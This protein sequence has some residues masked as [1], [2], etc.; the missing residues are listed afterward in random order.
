MVATVPAFT[1][2]HLLLAGVNIQRKRR[3]TSPVPDDWEGW[4]AEVFPGYLW[5]P[6]AE[7]HESFWEWVLSIEAD[8][9]A[10]P[11]V[12]IWPRGFAKSTSTEVAT[13]MLAARKRRKYVLYVCSTQDQADTHVA[14]IAGML[15][16]PAFARHFPETSRRKLGKYGNS[17]GWRRNRLRTLD[18]FTVDAIGMD[19]AAR[20]AKVDEDRPDFIIFDDIDEIL[21]SPGTV[22][23]KITSMT[24]SLLPA[25]AAHAAVLVAQNLIHPDGIVA[26]LADGRADFLADRI[27]SGPHPA[28]RGM[29]TERIDGKMVITGGESTWPAKTIADLQLDLDDV[30]ETAF[31]S[32]K[33]HE[34]DKLEGGIFGH[35]E[36]R[37]CE[38][39]EVPA[40][41]DV[42]V[43]VD[44]AVT[45]KDR[46]DSHGVQVDGIDSNGFLYRLFSW[47]HR[48]SP[49]DALRRAILKARELKASCIGVE[50]DQGGDTWRSVYEL[51]WRKLVEQG[52]IPKDERMIDFR[53]EKAGAIGPKTYRASQ[54]L[55]AYER[56]E[57]IHVRNG[58]FEILERGLRRYLL[59]KPYDLVDAAYWGWYGLTNP[60]VEVDIL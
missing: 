25:R 15:E 56:G 44:P 57:I 1:E 43:W 6:Y 37:H 24:K 27:V 53:E 12:A 10:D 39:H 50:T 32:E 18:G 51:T 54:M 29:V 47:E 48:T 8:R 3:A 36:F 46:S 22:A 59:R 58:T 34:V 38:P 11:F 17:Q 2:A 21:D 31:R 7:Y 42:Q 13:A 45:D 33:Q 4:L 23:K 41:Q 14:N 40:L 20:G 19:T 16:S 28:I 35:I 26:R 49:E 60:V 30:G 55:A 9:A 5:P 52:E